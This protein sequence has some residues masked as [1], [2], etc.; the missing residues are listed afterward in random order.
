MEGRSNLRIIVRKEAK[1][2]HG[3]RDRKSASSKVKRSKV[4]VS[5]ANNAHMVNRPYIPK[6]KAADFKLNGTHNGTRIAASLTGAITS[7]LKVVGNCSNHP[8]RGL[9]HIVAAALHAARIKSH[10]QHRSAWFLPRPSSLCFSSK[11]VS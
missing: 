11:L 9:G 8:C 10:F 6:R 3:R 7:N 4:K 2:R 1:E 5:M